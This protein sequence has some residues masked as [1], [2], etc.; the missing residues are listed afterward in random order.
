MEKKQTKGRQKIEMKKIEDEGDRLIAYSK[1]RSGIYKKASE[2]STLCGAE[3][4]MVSF[5]PS[6]KAF[7][8]GHPSIESVANRFLN[9]N[10]PPNDNTT[11]FVEA[12]RQARIH[13]LNQKYNELYEQLE[14]KKERGKG[15]KRMERNRPKGWWEAN[16]DELSLHEL[17]QLK[18]TIEEFQNNLYQQINDLNNGISSS[19][20]STQAINPS[21]PA[22]I[23]YPVT[24]TNPTK[25]THPFAAAN[26]AQEN[27]VDNTIG[28][29]TPSVPHGYGYWRG[30]F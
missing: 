13:E 24:A 16:V 27:S 22:Q 12:H 30:Q 6:G 18:A 21:N 28:T 26:S 5:S 20:S 1:R 7:S 3:I 15:L 14:A 11:R 17:K 10:P 29:S 23:T 2:L 8:Y 19:A 25:M 4:A 9:H